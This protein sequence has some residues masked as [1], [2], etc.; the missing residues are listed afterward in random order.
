MLY[1]LISSQRLTF[2][3]FKKRAFYQ[4]VCNS[5]TYLKELH[6]NNNKEERIAL[7]KLLLKFLRV[8]K[9]KLKSLLFIP[10]E[11]RRIKKELQKKELEGY[12]F[13]QQAFKTNEKVK[14]WVLQKDY[15]NYKLP[16]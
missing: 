6:E 7:L 4:G 8:S 1:H 15:W 5:F 2:E 3:Y 11:I 9:I 10:K 16:V 12:H 14:E 13:H